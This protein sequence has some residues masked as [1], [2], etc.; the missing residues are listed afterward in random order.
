MRVLFLPGF[1]PKLP[2]NVTLLALAPQNILVSHKSLESNRPPRMDPPRA[3]PHLGAEA[4]AKPVCEAGARVHEHA[5]RVDAA[6]ERAAGSG[7]LG[8]DT[9]GVVRAVLV[10]VRDGGCE[11][12]HGA[13]G[14]RER[15]VL[16]RVGFGWGWEHVRFDEGCGWAVGGA[17]GEECGE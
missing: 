16:G 4:I 10:D 1:P 9:V 3:D 8:D 13:H 14:E 11:G 2:D 7:R 5:G 15:E 12:A 6:H 17:G